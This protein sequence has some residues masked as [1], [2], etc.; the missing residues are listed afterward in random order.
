MTPVV[1]VVVVVV[2]VDN[3][4]NLCVYMPSAVEYN[5]I[6]FTACRC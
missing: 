3:K 1:V 4:G 5:L 6:F 2:V